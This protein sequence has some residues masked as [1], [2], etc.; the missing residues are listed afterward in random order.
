M[1]VDVDIN[2]DGFSDILTL[3]MFENQYFKTSLGDDVQML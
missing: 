1:G 3:D 2:H